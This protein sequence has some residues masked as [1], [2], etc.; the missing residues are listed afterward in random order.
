MWTR[1][2]GLSV[3]LLWSGTGALAATPPSAPGPA[4]E[5]RLH[6]ASAEASS[7]LV[8]DWNKF[9]ENYLPLYV[10]DDDPRTA[11]SLK[12]EGIGE[13]LRVHVTSMEG[14]TR[15]RL[16]L[17]NGYQKTPR[18]WE[19]NSRA[20]EVTL[21]LLPSK[22]TV[23][24]ALRDVSDW[25]E[26][27][28]EQPPGAFEAVE[29]R[30]KS[31]Y[32]GKK[33]D[34]LCLS[35]LQLYVTATSTDNPAFE[36]QRLEKLA[37]W[38][39]ERAAAAKIFR[40]KLGQSLPIAAQY[41]ATPRPAH[42]AEPRNQCQSGPTCW[43]SYTLG[44]AARAAGK[45]KHAE[46]LATAAALSQAS[47]ATMTPVKIASRD[48]RPIPTVDGLC[49]P[50]LNSCQE[51]P[52]ANALPLPITRQLGY[53]STEALALVEQSGLP[54][55]ADVVA[56][57]PPACHHQGTTT[58]AWA[59][60]GGSAGADGAGGPGAG[61][62]TALRALLLVACGL[63]EGREGPFAAHHSQLLVYGGDG[64]L[65]VVAEDDEAAVLDWRE[66]T[67]GPKL[68]RATVS[69]SYADGDIDVEATTGVVA[70]K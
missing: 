48:K 58:F 67:D 3:A 44:R 20:H 66:G 32:P 47:F 59:L 17:R 49:T 56:L 60:R 62:P 13:W 54:S 50:S 10:G 21:V 6:V 61:G 70:S 11:W 25:Q 4:R 16:R 9:E 28:V 22:K 5:R 19:A 7:Y 8:N 33:Y 53:L 52:C 18:L 34:D 51:D 1:S 14:A 41:V 65:E 39:K 24:V 40:T 37:A 15:V 63:V 43:M 12:T 31:V 2:V 64:R 38:K 27:V 45:G 29:L 69:K 35:D 26:V 46:A 30:V 42:E 68:A 57:K 55:F 23:D 36:K